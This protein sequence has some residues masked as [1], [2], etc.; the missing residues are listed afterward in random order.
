MYPAVSHFNDFMS[1]QLTTFWKEPS[2][3]DFTKIT[4]VSFNISQRFPII[5]ALMT[6]FFLWFALAVVVNM[7]FI[8]CE[9]TNVLIAFIR[10][11]RHDLM[12]LELST[13]HYS[14]R[15]QCGTVLATTYKSVVAFA[16]R[17][18]NPKTP[19]IEAGSFSALVCPVTSLA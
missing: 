3:I 2:F 19:A 1:C 12:S 18:Y 14:T 16:P 5:T 10:F 13:E 11:T 9:V 4:I 17:F 8:R 6:V 7:P 15:I